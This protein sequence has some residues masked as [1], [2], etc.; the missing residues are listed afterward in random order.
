[1]PDIHSKFPPSAAERHLNCPPSLLL[2]EQCPKTTNDAAEEGTYAHW[3]AENK[4]LALLGRPANNDEPDFKGWNK[5]DMDIYT[6]QYIDFI[7]AERDYL[8]AQIIIPERQ[9]KFTNWVEGGFGTSDCVVISEDTISIIDFK[10]GFGPVKVENN[11]QLKIYALGAVQEFGILCPDLKHI[12]ISIFQPRISNI[13]TWELSYEDLIFWADNFVKPQAELA[14]AGKGQHREGPWCKY[15]RA[16]ALCPLK[17]A[18]AQ[19][20][21]AQMAAT[22]NQSLSDGAVSEDEIAKLLPQLES[23]EDWIKGVKEYALARAQEGKEWPGMELS[24]SRSSRSFTDTAR[25][26]TVANQLGISD[27]I[28]ETKLLSVAQL[29]K[30][31]GKKVF[32]DNFAPLVTTTPGSPTL[33]PKKSK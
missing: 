18:N 15:C 26:E 32:A 6:D 31:V 7:K 14:L 28:H 27:K 5:A 9:V 1:M 8:K 3:V 29:E 11:T 12:R 23:I 20:V 33:V 19:E 25:V 4:L 30:V 10:Y 16:K 17:N 24:S 2:E 22:Q 21:L 13:G